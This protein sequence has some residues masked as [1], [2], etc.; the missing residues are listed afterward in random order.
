MPLALIV[1]DEP[2][3]RTFLRYVL[4]S[5]GY[6]VYEVGSGYEAEAV[7]KR[8][9]FDLVVLDVR[10]PDIVGLELMPLL[11]EAQSGTPVLVVSA[12]DVGLEALAE[13][14]DA[15]LKKPFS[16][17]DMTMIVKRFSHS[18]PTPYNPN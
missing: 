15:F 7:I 1:E 6:K 14:A 9:A 2:K 13:G 5:L 18:A 12:N 11:Q 16:Y 10:L 4:M 3:V 8:S 17:A